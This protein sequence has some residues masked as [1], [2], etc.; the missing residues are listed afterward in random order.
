VP[1]NLVADRGAEQDHEP[2]S[3]ERVDGSFVALDL[4]GESS[5]AA[6]HDSPNRLRVE[7][8]VEVQTHIVAL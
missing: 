7:A 3:H 4:Y 5:E 8:L 2:V 1:R 6:A